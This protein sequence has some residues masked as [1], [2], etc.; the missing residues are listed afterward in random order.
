MKRIL[1]MVSA[2]CLVLG[3]FAQNAAQVKTHVTY[4]RGTTI[5]LIV[6][7]KSEMSVSDI[8]ASSVVKD[9]FKLNDEESLK[10]IRTWDDAYGFNHKRYQVYRGEHE[11]FGAVLTM[12]QKDGI[13]KSV[14]GKYFPNVKTGQVDITEDIALE[15]ALDQVRAEKY[16][17]ESP[18]DEAMLKR[19]T[20]DQNSTYFP[21]GK[22]KYVAPNGNFNSGVMVLAYEFEIHSKLPETRSMV[23]VDA[24]NGETVWHYDALMHESV[25]GTAE[26]GYLGTVEIVT[27]SLAPDDYVLRDGTRGDSVITFNTQGTFDEGGAIDWRDDDNYWDATNDD[28]YA[29]DAHFG[30]EMSYDYFLNIHGRNSYDGLGSTVFTYANYGTNYANANWNGQ[31]LALGNGGSFSSSFATLDIVAHE[32]THGVTEYSANLIYN[33]ESGALNESFSDIFGQCI[34]ME[35]QPDSFNYLIGE[36]TGNAL[37]SMA[38]PNS[39]GDPDTYFGNFWASLSGGDNGGVHTNSG[40]QNYWFYVL[41]EGDTATNDLGNDYSVEGLGR[42]K[43]EQIAYRNLNEYLTASSDFEEARLFA[44]QSANDIYGDCSFETQQVT[45][46][47]YAVGVGE[48]YNPDVVA[49]MEIDKWFACEFPVTVNIKNTSLNE[50]YHLWTL[51]DGEQTTIQETGLVI[52]EPGTYEV[53]LF[54]SNSITCFNGPSTVTKTLNLF[55]ID[56]LKQD[57]CNLSTFLYGNGAGITYFELGSIKQ[58]SV[59]GSVGYQDFTCDANTVLMTDEDHTYTIDVGPTVPQ[60]VKVWADLDYDGIMQSDELIDSAFAG[61]GTY[62]GTINVAEGDVVLGH[63]LRL[64]VATSLSSYGKDLTPCDSTKNGQYEDYTVMFINSEN[65]PLGVKEEK[66]LLTQLKLYPNPA[67]DLVSF[68]VDDA[69]QYIDVRN[70]LG[71]LVISE[72][73]RGSTSF[74]VQNLDRGLYYVVARGKKTTYKSTLIKE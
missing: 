42:A 40:V 16:F 59:D 28:K 26:S 73:L 15:R 68:N 64:R 55:Q 67:T 49:S 41:M 14:T 65:Y 62:E 5:P 10:M 19:M 56:P 60:I 9:L 37:R 20:K 30:S 21:S 36:N 46:A 17:W 63:A 74:S 35:I 7:P 12:H 22:L 27:D 71:Q 69:V 51:P 57:E 34:E 4:K 45:D 2:S 47:W 23:Y 11:V 29:I 31:R 13:L 8:E 39:Y 43:A 53:E 3:S 44:I 6:K 58:T 33:A 32:L 18:K 24:E 50:D 38:D 54:A 66:E 70:A 48:P 25:T 61:V 52:D 1:L 72:E